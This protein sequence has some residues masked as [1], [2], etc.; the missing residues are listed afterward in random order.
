[1][2]ASVASLGFLPMALST[3]AGAEVQRPLA[4][5]VIG[6]LITATLLT[7]VVLPV[8]YSLVKGRRK[9]ER[10]ERTG[11]SG[12]KG[13]L[14]LGTL[15][16]FLCA[17]ATLSLPLKAQRLVSLDEAVQEATTQN[18]L[19]KSDQLGIQEQQ[20]LLPTSFNL[21][22]TAVDVQYLSLIHI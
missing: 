8:L 22:K 1:M 20:A 9:A 10:E 13:N 3:S 2:T 21:P 18:L 14:G 11:P 17:F 15:T 4:T 7:L 5:V 6:G 19:I 12:G 16:L